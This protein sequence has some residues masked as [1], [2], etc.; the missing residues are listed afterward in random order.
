MTEHSNELDA[1]ERI[2][3]LQERHAASGPRGAPEP[4]CGRRAGESA[5]A[6]RSIPKRARAPRGNA[7]PARRPPPA[8]C[9]AV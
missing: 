3:R 9:S 2:R 8:G 4:G 7:G 6:G 5:G 1:A